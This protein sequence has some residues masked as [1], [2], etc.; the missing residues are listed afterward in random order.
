MGSWRY[1]LKA[2]G[3]KWIG[4]LALFRAACQELGRGHYREDKTVEAGLVTGEDEV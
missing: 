3:Q 2:Y 1:A 4:L